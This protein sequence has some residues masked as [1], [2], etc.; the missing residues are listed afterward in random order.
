MVGIAKADGIV[1]VL[2]GQDFLGVD[3]RDKRFKGV[4]G[5]L[6]DPSCSGSG[7]QGR[8]DV[9]TL[10]LPEAKPPGDPNSKRSKKRK[11][12]GKDKN[13]GRDAKRGAGSSGGKAAPG[14]ENEMSVA[15][16]D[17]ERL[18]KL[19]NLQTRIVEHALSFPSARRVTYSTCSIHGLENENVVARVLGSE[20]AR[21][22]GW[23]VLKRSEQPS[24]LREWKHRGVKQD[25]KV[26]EDANGQAIHWE[27]GQ[28]ELDA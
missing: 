17:T 4:T 22:R 26:V 23:R 10:A 5:L 21:R 20:V 28:E 13:E 11:R 24:G 12:S 18:I 15:G 25:G 8:D 9:P 1:N 16:D 19:S 27:L 3:P 14:E 2:E 6:L 7:I